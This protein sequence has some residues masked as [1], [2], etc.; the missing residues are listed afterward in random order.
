MK[1]IVF[2]FAL[3]AFL[4]SGCRI[5]NP[6]YS[7]RIKVTN[8]DGVAIQNVV[9]EASV[10]V[11]G[12]REEAYMVDTTSF[13]GVVE[14]EYDYEAVFKILGTRG[15]NPYTHIGCGFVKLE[16]NQTVESSIILLPYDPSDPG[17]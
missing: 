1:K 6:T 2:L 14:F 5:D 12:H 9:V 15:G 7:F 10:D 13:D 3:S 11:P 16:A 17:C 8:P 4:F